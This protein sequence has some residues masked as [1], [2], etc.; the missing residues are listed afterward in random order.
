MK[1]AVAHLIP[2]IEAEKERGAAAREAKG[3]VVLATVKGDVH[4]I[5]KN[6]V[7]VVLQCNN[8]EVIDLGVM[9]PAA[10]DPRD[11]AAGGRR[12]RRPAGLITPSLEEMAHVAG[13]MEREGFRVPLLIGGATTSRVHTAVKI[14]PQLSRARWCTCST[15]RAR[16]A[17]RQPAQPGRCATGSW[18]ACARVRGGPRRSAAERPADERRQPLA[19]ARRNRLADR[20]G[21]RRR[22]R[23]RCSPASRRSTTTR[24]RSWS[25]ASTGRRS[26][27]PGSW[28]ASIPAI[29][30][31]PWSARRRAD[32]FADAR[33]D[34]RAHRRE[35][36][37]T[38]RGVVGFWPA[39]AVGDDIEIYADEA[40]AR[41]AAR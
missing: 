12:H 18:P 22:R 25:R 31:D 27:R 39:N 1:K 14:A 2:Y 26:S 40:R 10:T 32:L 37:L 30:D 29:L 7:G 36:W 34:A 19:A 20:L 28:P 24:S 11:R 23:R 38:A 15:R 33:G 9:V 21:R 5:G 17:W 8:Y 3:R 4:D 16:S 35:R 41:A 13:E 6:I